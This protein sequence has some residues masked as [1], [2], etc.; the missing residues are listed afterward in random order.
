ML[1]IFHPIKLLLGVVI[2]ETVNGAEGRERLKQR[3]VDLI[4]MDMN[5]PEMDGI[6]PIKSVRTDL[7]RETSIIIITRRE[8]GDRKSGMEAGANACITKPLD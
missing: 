2:T 1:F 3:N 7:N 4:L 6:G 8:R 5:M